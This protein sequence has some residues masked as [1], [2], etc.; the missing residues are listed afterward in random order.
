MPAPG[1]RAVSALPSEACTAAAH[2]SRGNAERGPGV[3]G[4]IAGV[5]L[6]DGR[7]Y[8][9]LCAGCQA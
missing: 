2:V 5:D 4:L 3:L 6:I 8:A 1:C 9:I 7:H